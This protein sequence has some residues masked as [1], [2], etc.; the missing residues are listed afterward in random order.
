MQI[1][2]GPLSPM[3]VQHEAIEAQKAMI[4]SMSR[5]FATCSC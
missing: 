4:N 5:R 1:I 3:Y 2:R